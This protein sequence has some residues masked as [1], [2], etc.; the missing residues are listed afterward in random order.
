[1]ELTIIT[2]KD[3]RTIHVYEDSVVELTFSEGR[4]KNLLSQANEKSVKTA[5]TYNKDGKKYVSAQELA[6]SYLKHG[7]CK[8]YEAEQILGACHK[9]K[10]TVDKTYVI[11]NFKCEEGSVFELWKQDNG[12]KALLSSKW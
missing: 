4:L 3:R 2:K 9:G 6:A 12:D 5:T 10:F 8:K 7:R 11:E 1:M